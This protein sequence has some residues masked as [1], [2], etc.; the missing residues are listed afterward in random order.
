MNPTNFLTEVNN[1]VHCG[2]KTI[3][4]V[5]SFS[6]DIDDADDFASD[7]FVT[8]EDIDDEFVTDDK[9]DDV[10]DFMMDDD[11]VT[12]SVE[13]TATEERVS[14][15]SSDTDTISE[16]LQNHAHVS[17]ELDT[18][19]EIHSITV[20]VKQSTEAESLKDE[21]DVW[22]TKEF[23]AS[24]LEEWSDRF[25]EVANINDAFEQWLRLRYNVKFVD[26]S[27]ADNLTVS[28]MKHISPAVTPLT[29]EM[30]DELLANKGCLDSEELRVTYQ[31]LRIL[32]F[33]VQDVLTLIK[34]PNFN[35]LFKKYR[36][37]GVPVV[38]ALG[39]ICL[40]G[41]FE[42][43]QFD[44]T[45]KSQPVNVSEFLRNYYSSSSTVL[46]KFAGATPDIMRQLLELYEEKGE[47]YE[48]PVKFAKH[49]AL[50]DVIR[51]RRY[52]TE[53]S[54]AEEF[55]L[56]GAPDWFATGYGEGKFSGL[57]PNASVY[58]AIANRDCEQFG[59]QQLTEVEDWVVESYYVNNTPI[60][61]YKQLLLF[62]SMGVIIDE[63]KG[64]P[65]LSVFLLNKFMSCVGESIAIP[66]TISR[67]VLFV[68]DGKIKMI[69]AEQVLFNVDYVHNL[70]NSNKNYEMCLTD[71]SSMLIIVE[72]S[73]L[74]AISKISHMSCLTYSSIERWANSNDKIDPLHYNALKVAEI[75]GADVSDLISKPLEQY[76]AVD[77][78]FD[79][80][81][82][83]V[84]EVMCMFNC[85][86]LMQTL[87]ILIPLI[88]IKNR[89][90]FTTSFVKAYF[91]EVNNQ[92][93]SYSSLDTNY[94]QLS[95][96]GAPSALTPI[97]KL[98][99]YLTEVS[100]DAKCEIM[101]MDNL[102][103][104]RIG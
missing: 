100:R 18:L 8:D 69:D 60:S 39:K 46:T 88:S 14:G 70:L 97:S 2:E 62:K 43:N 73:M 57:Q 22:C 19:M 25:G 47:M 33:E 13:D 27:L 32:R 44:T 38:G 3:E 15:D 6:D 102:I 51:A 23:K 63:A 81:L 52:Y 21:F 16:V 20:P 92:V 11:F 80:A 7:D 66:R 93:D 36:N 50:Q 42:E 98:Y 104:F 61:E 103:Y 91:K 79:Y 10:D 40:K 68:S 24:I 56:N 95:L 41:E 101:L 48:M 78:C 90:K 17:E 28:D 84:P 99:T 1:Y 74:G 83:K 76:N 5:T 53:C 12:D 4:A 75:C 82:N 67:M 87:K 9:E 29:S 65:S 59:L 96:Y 31:M 37:K 94:V 58:L 85:I 54:I 49:P 26:L 89:L 55:I 30:I 34:I 64:V 77:R 71:D 72:S 35:E 45:V 86:G